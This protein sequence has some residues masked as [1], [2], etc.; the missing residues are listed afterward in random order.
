M[1]AQSFSVNGILNL[2]QEE[3]VVSLKSFL[4]S[5]GGTLQNRERT[6][7]PTRAARMG[8]W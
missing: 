6:G 7:V 3:V 1:P 8:W 4:I 5:E 2:S